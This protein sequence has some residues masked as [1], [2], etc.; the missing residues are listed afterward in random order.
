MNQHPRKLA[1]INN[2]SSYN[3]LAIVYTV[4]PVL[5]YNIASHSYYALVFARLKVFIHPNT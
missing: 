5:S 4:L 2:N 1:S 3:Y